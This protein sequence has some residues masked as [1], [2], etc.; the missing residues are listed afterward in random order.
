MLNKYLHNIPSTEAG[1]TS[2]KECVLGDFNMAKIITPDPSA[3]NKKF[4]NNSLMKKVFTTA[5]SYQVQ[6]SERAVSN[7][8]KINIFMQKG[9]RLLVGS[10][11]LCL[12]FLNLL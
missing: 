3:L 11:F 10:M 9:L 5:K 7:D 2:I 1:N 4:Q 8:F 6:M 12:M